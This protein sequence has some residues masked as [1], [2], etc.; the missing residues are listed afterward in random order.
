[1]KTISI[2]TVTYN[3]LTHLQPTVDSVISQLCDRMEYIIIDGASKD[4][5]DAYLQK[6]SGIHWI[7][8]P[9]QGI[10]DAMNKGARVAMGRWLLYLNAGDLLL[11]GVVSRLLTDLDDEYDCYYGHVVLTIPYRGETYYKTKRA[12]EDVSKLRKGMICSH[13][14]FLC[15]RSDLLGI[16]GFD[17]S[18]SS[19]ADWDLISRL[20]REGKRFFCLDFFIA[21]Y[22]RYGNSSKPHIWERHRVRKN[23]DF[24]HIIDW[25]IIKDI[26]HE[27]KNISSSLVLGE[28]KKKLYIIMKNCKKYSGGKQLG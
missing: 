13:Q 20:Y 27:A 9:D 8:E 19:A 15:K 16:G 2:I 10:Y 1:M 12:E 23:N 24:Y 28:Y 22:D 14:S 5:T 7:S 21:T 3:D 17:T 26:A 25:S 4:G 11:P 18:F 6:L